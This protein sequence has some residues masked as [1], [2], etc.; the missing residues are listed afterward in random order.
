MPRK[1]TYKQLFSLPLEAEQA[2]LD[3]AD[4]GTETRLRPRRPS[5]AS[6]CSA[7]RHSQSLE[8]SPSGFRRRTTSDPPGP[9]AEG[10]TAPGLIAVG[11]RDAEA[12]WA[13]GVAAD[14]SSLSG[15]LGPAHRQLEGSR[16]RGPAR[17][18]PAPDAGPLHRPRNLHPRRR[19]R[20]RGHGDALQGRRL[21]RGR[22][23]HEPGPGSPAVFARRR[24]QSRRLGPL[25]HQT[26]RSPCL[27][28]HRRFSSPLPPSRVSALPCSLS[29]PWPPA[30]LVRGANPFALPAAYGA[31]SSS[32]PRAAS[33]TARSEQEALACPCW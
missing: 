15:R 32:S 4:V 33:A 19:P 27:D 29:P 3:T 25:H 22:R 14:P 21:R 2:T 6:H 30:R 5:P 17:R 28:G 23:R 9:D 10:A 1:H 12:G 7:R 11:A 13:G 31:S 20:R 24:V 18:L 8:A 16:P 26:R